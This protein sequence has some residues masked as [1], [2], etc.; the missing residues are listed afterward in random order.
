MLPGALVGMFLS[1]V[2]FA[3]DKIGGIKHLPYALRRRERAR[4]RSPRSFIVSLH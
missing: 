4:L 3:G 1:V 2:P